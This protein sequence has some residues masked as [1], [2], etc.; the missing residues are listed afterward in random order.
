GVRFG[1]E[2]GANQDVL[3]SHAD[4]RFAEFE[5][6][7]NLVEAAAPFFGG[8]RP[9]LAAG[10]DVGGEDRMTL[11]DKLFD[12]AAGPGIRRL[13]VAVNIEDAWSRCLGGLEIKRR[14]PDA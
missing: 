3:R 6:H 4:E 1:Q 13:I 11:E 12:G 10:T 2:A 5:G 7:E 14:Q 8:L 9:D